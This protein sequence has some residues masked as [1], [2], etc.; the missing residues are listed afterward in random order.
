MNSPVGQLSAVAA[1]LQYSSKRVDPPGG[2][3]IL[4]HTREV[5]P[6]WVSFRDPKPADGYKFVQKPADGL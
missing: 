4:G 2:T 3:P 6:E 1:M 5:R